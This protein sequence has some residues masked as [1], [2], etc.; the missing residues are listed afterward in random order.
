MRDESAAVA[1]LSRNCMPAVELLNSKTM[2]TKIL[3]THITKLN[4]AF[5]LTLPIPIGLFNRWRLIDVACTA[6]PLSSRR[7]QR[8]PQAITLYARTMHPPSCFTAMF[9]V[10]RPVIQSLCRCLARLCRSI[11]DGIADGTSLRYL[12]TNTA[13]AVAF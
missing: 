13:V 8:I 4:I 2:L 5:K 7:E 12:R 1:E 11:R 10:A 6:T 3:L 9:T